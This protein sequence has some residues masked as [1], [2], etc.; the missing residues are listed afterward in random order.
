M[1]SL[2]IVLAAATALTLGACSGAQEAVQTSIDRTVMGTLVGRPYSAAT[3]TMPDLPF[4]PGREPVYGRLFSTANLSDGSRLYRHLIRDVGQTSRTS[5]MGLRESET[6][7]YSYRLMYFRVDPAGTIVE[8]ANGFWLGESQRCVGYVGNIFQTC[9]NPQ[10][11]AADVAFFDSLV[12][13]ADGRPVT[14]AWL[15]TP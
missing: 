5:F 4:G 2:A 15:K 14:S 13:T 12:R 3:A 8:V 1:K 11:L 7:R 6:V 10:S 9:E